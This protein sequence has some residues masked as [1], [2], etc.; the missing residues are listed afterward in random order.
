MDIIW[1]FVIVFVVSLVATMFWLG[2]TSN[3]FVESLIVAI[4]ITVIWVRNKH[5]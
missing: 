5:G 1:E 4:A 3:I 2:I